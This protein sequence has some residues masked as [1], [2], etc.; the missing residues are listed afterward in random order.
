LL[1]SELRL[2]IS[3]RSGVQTIPLLAE[4][5]GVRA[6]GPVDGQNPVQVVDLV[7]QQLGPVPLQI[8]LMGLT[9][10]VLIAD[11]DVVRPLNLISVQGWS[12]STWTMRTGA[13]I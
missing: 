3:V 10:Q 7:L 12:I 6:V 5:K 9:L 4:A 2:S 13:P 11:S 8:L 1:G